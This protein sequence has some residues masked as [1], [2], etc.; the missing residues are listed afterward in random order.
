MEVLGRSKELGSLRGLLDASTPRLI[1]VSGI[2]G[3]GKSTL[4]RH[5]GRDYRTLF[6]RCAPLPDLAQRARIVDR[7][8]EEAAD[9]G[10]AGLPRDAT[11][12]QIFDELVRRAAE[13][14][15]PF[16]L[17]LDDAHRLA[18]ARSRVAEPLGSALRAAADERIPFHLVLV[19]PEVPL[20][21]IDPGPD[22]PRAAIEIGPLPFRA[23]AA[24][25]PGSRPDDRLL[26]Y[27]TF[28]GIPSALRHLDR[29]ATLMTNVRRLMLSEDGP[30]HDAGALWLDRDLQTPARYY[31]IMAVLAKGEADWAAVHHGVP[32]LS[33]SGQLAPYLNRLTELG[34]VEARRSVDATERSRSTRYA[35]RDPLLAFWFRFVF[36]SRHRNPGGPGVGRD[37]YARAA[38]SDLPAHMETIFPSL[39]RQHMTHDAI[40]TVGATAREGGSL[41]GPGYELPVAGILAS[42]AAYYG[43]C[44]WTD[45]RPA[46]PGDPF[47]EIEAAMRETR[48]GFGRERRIR[49][50]FTGGRAPR[51][52]HREAARRGDARVIDAEA[53]AG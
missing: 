17:V 43:A 9:Q 6:H 33:R 21:D 37:D 1:T 2:R 28:G 16:V 44:R 49:L 41:W 35:V 20:P 3:G 39:C 13:A 8:D 36:E 12:R 10:S 19:G 34:L 31:A 29:T 50:L 38:Q 25:L 11:W 45:A 18:E 5:V 26:A 24:L 4:V 42:G 32:D 46:S 22:V 23:A 27:A 48:Y 15:R 52:L 40:E 53:L 30:L 51:A 7:L 47:D 14:P